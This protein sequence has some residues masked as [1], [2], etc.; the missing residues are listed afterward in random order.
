[1]YFPFK[2]QEITGVEFLVPKNGKPSTEQDAANASNGE[3]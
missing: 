3:L 2:G 1:M